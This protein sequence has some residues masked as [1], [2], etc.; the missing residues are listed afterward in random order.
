MKTNTRE[1]PN[2][3]LAEMPRPGDYELGS[4]GSRAAAR[5]LLDAKL[6]ADQRKRFRVMLT[7]IGR[8]LSLETSGCTRS[9]WPDGTVFEN[10]RFDGT[11]PTEA[12]L[13]HLEKLI[14]KIPIDG[15]EHTFAEMGYS[16]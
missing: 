5:A 7:T 15:K 2:L 4:I 13:E 14:C 3:Q 12:Q 16:Q 11:D 6:K 9:L 10:V 1:S 8:P